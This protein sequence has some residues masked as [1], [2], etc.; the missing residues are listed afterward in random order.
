MTAIVPVTINGV[1]Y[2]ANSEYTSSA[3]ANAFASDM[4]VFSDLFGIAPTDSDTVQAQI[5]AGNYGPD[6]SQAM[7]NLLNLAQ[8]GITTTVNGFTQTYYLTAQMSQSVDIVMRTLQ[9]AG[10]VNAPAAT[11]TTDSNTLWNGLISTWK[12][13]VANSS[14]VE[15]ALKQGVN[16]LTGNR[17]LQALVELIYVTSGSDYISSQLGSLQQAL[18]TTQG[19]LADLATFQTLHNKITVNGVNIPGPASLK[20]NFAAQGSLYFGNVY[21]SLPT[22]LASVG[23]AG[24]IQFITDIT[25]VRDSFIHEISILGPITP[26]LAGGGADPN[27][28]LANLK[29]LVSTLNGLSGFSRTSTAGVIVPLTTASML[30]INSAAVSGHHASAVFNGLKKWV[31]DGYATSNNSQA[32]AFQNQITVAITAGQSLNSQNQ[33]SVRNYMYV[34]EEFYKSASAMLTTITQII[35]KMAQHSSGS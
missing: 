12:T 10:I 28:L 34:F 24:V 35:Q 25:R 11:G 29:T 30:A 18:Q 1:V 3:V 14:V 13:V 5:N 22:S 7:Q 31:L 17:S 19:A 26:P 33:E 20:A 27:T 21:P 16:A 8:N 4:Q 2:N 23:A 15:A 32:G 6:V 9:A